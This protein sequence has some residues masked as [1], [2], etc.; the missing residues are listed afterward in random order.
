MPLRKAAEQ[1]NLGIFVGSALN[2]GTL[3]S[4]SKYASMGAEQYNLVTAENACKFGPTE[5]EKDKFDFTKCDEVY[6]FAVAHSMTFRGH[7]T[8][9][10]NDNPSWLTN[11]NYDSSEL[12]DILK[13]HITIVLGHYDKSPGAYSWDV[14]NEAVS[15]DAGSY[16]NI[17]KNNVWYPKVKNYVFD[18]FTYADEA[19]KSKGLKTKLFYNDYSIHYEDKKS[20]AVYSMIQNMQSEKIPIDGLGVQCH[21]N[22]GDYPLSQ[23]KLQSNFKRFTDLGI[24]IHITELDDACKSNDGCKWSSSEEKK[25]AEMYQILLQACIATPRCKSYESWGF[26]DKYTWVG[27][28]THPLPFDDNYNPKTAA[29]YIENTFLNHSKSAY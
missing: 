16:P 1:S 14:V 23:S 21:F 4:D 25:Q 19:R 11:G 9:W 7:N 2:A 28:D 8:C 6:N 18:A 22:M 27:S 24:E 10:G 3:K 12:E 15:D 26:T 20:N 17:Y 5:P 29:F 13:N